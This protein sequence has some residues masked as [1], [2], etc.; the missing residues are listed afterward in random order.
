[1]WG[2][3]CGCANLRLG[4]G[5]SLDRRSAWN[6]HPS[7]D[8]ALSAPPPPLFC[9][10]RFL[11]FPA[12]AAERGCLI[13][14]LSTLLQLTPQELKLVGIRN[15]ACPALNT[16]SLHHCLVLLFCG[17]AQRQA[18]H[19]PPLLVRTACMCSTAGPGEG[20]R[21]H[22]PRP[23]ALPP[24]V[25]HVLLFVEQ[26][27]CTRSTATPAGS[28]LRRDV[29]ALCCACRTSSYPRGI[30]FICSGGSA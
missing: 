11:T 20:G 25:N 2:V 17:V 15:G 13:P 4:A 10:L 1:M 9:Q 27:G 28:P 21:T 22:A 3:G 26:A 7:N 8:C 6:A 30:T 23:G 18:S 24:H 19:I 16:F 5:H 12:G 29:D 14:V